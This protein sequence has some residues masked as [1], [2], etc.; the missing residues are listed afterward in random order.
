MHGYRE[1]ERARER[2]RGIFGYR[3]RARK[4]DIEG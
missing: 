1:K 3:E 2:Q 4:R